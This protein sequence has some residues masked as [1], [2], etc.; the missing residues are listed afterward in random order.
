M[1]HLRRLNIVGNA[2]ARELFEEAIALDPEYSIA[3]AAL[4]Q[5]HLLDVWLGLTKSPDKSIEKSVELAQ[6]A[7]ALDD[8]PA[9]THTLWS[10][11]YRLKRQYDKAVAEGERAVALNPNGADAHASFAPILFSADKQEEALAMIK[12]AIRLNP[13]P[14]NIYF[15]YLGTAYRN[16]G[17][18]AESI[19]AYKKALIGEPDNLFAHIGL[20]ATYSLLGRNE[21]ARAEAAEVRRIAPKLSLDYMEKITPSKNRAGLERYIDA[22]RKAGLK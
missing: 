11:I 2:Q 21:E 4:A 8:T 3:Y 7:L 5:T 17:Q 16:T 12:K 20:V 14:P 13:F 9:L 22:L 6:K 1:E 10:H 15:Q 18:Y 19:T